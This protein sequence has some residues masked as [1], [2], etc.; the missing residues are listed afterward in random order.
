MRGEERRGAEEKRHKK[1]HGGKEVSVERTPE[2][3]ERED[4][5]GGEMKT[6]AFYCHT[7]SVCSDLQ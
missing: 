1:Q 4:R 7:M 6:H 3:C 5:E 2:V